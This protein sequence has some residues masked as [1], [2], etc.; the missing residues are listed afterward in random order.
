MYAC[1]FAV[2]FV[3]YELGSVVEDLKEVGL[4]FDGQVIQFLVNF[5]VDSLKNTI[6]AFMWPVAII[7]TSQPW[8]A[9]GLGIAFFLFPLTLKKPIERWLFDGVPAD[10][11]A[12]KTSNEASKDK[13][14]G[15][16]KDAK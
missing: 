15:G 3:I 1:G 8:G 2:S 16:S 11:D 7:Q 12:A 14:A 5:F 6:K 10:G 4:L 9:I 13:A